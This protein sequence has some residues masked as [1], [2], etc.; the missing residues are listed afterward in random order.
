MQVDSAPWGRL[1]EVGGGGG[2]A[3]TVE[4][5]AQIIKLIKISTKFLEYLNT[6][7]PNIKLKLNLKKTTRS[8]F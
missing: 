1:G 5:F 7:H 3:E 6:R 8:H 2:E 4:H